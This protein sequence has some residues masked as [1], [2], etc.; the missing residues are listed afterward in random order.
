[1]A[2]SGE[3]AVA[4]LDAESPVF[5]A[6][7]TGV[8]LARGGLTGRKVARH[9]RE[10]RPELPVIYMTGGVHEWSV[11]GVPNSLLLTKPF[12]P[13]QVVIAVS[14][15]LNAG[16]PGQ[17]NRERRPAS[18][19]V[20][21]RRA[22]PHPWQPVRS[23]LILLCNQLCDPKPTVRP[24]LHRFF[25]RLLPEIPARQAGTWGGV[26][27]AGRG[28]RTGHG[29]GRTRNGPASARGRALGGEQLRLAQLPFL[30]GQ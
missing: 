22:G 14:Q 27:D 2:R 3:D 9:A 24:G 30:N 1:M 20:A 8:N 10:L 12:A 11:H 25:V 21:A 29:A 23:T 4:K 13:A 19:R 17:F 5:R 26:E 15:L 6:P 16:G 28:R 18:G 7:I